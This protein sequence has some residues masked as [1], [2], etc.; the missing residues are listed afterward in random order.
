MTDLNVGLVVAEAITQ[1]DPAL[2]VSFVVVEALYANP[3]RLHT[4]LVAAEVLRSVD[5]VAPAGG[6]GAL[7]VGL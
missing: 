5:A 4:A 2:N 7:L 6:G 1:P 3:L